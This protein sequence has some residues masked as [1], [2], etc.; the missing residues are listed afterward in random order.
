MVYRWFSF[1]I[2]YNVPFSRKLSRFYEEGV[3]NDKYPLIHLD[4]EIYF[5]RCVIFTGLFI[6]YQTDISW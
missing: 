5:G 1:C 4:Y 2:Q 3:I 6:Y